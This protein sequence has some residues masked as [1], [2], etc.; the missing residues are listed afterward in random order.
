MAKFSVAHSRLDELS[1]GGQDDRS[2][3]L[4]E[5]FR[6][7]EEQS[8]IDL[9]APTRLKETVSPSIIEFHSQST[10]RTVQ[11]LLDMWNK[12]PEPATDNQSLHT[13]H[14][15]EVAQEVEQ[16]RQIERPA[17]IN[18]LAPSIDPCLKDFVRTGSFA[19]LMQFPLAF[20][21]VVKTTSPRLVARFHP[22][23]HIRATTDFA[24]TV[25]EPLTGFYDDYVRPVIWV[26][27]SKEEVEA[28]TLLLI[29]QFEAN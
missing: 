23:R 29:S 19:L 24:N 17:K 5:D 12:L 13:E 7:R 3:S 26:L 16:E 22:W 9:Y 10:D 20:D 25:Q 15:R 28:S 14:E 1:N 6:E 4:I 8:L 21:N 18:P 2:R 27:T 11:T